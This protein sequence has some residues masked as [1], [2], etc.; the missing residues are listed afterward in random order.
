MKSK[1]LHESDGRRTITVIL[2]SGDEAVRCLREFVA[3]SASGPLTAIGA[4]SGAELA[5]LDWKIQ[6]LSMHTRAGAGRGGP[7][8]QSKRWGRKQV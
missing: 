4:L 5:Y 6:N 7:G 8:A 3:A 1:L 2:Q